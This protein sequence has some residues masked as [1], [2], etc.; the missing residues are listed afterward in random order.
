[1]FER[2]VQMNGIRGQTGISPIKIVEV[3]S[4]NKCPEQRN[5]LAMSADCDIPDGHHIRESTRDP[6]FYGGVERFTATP[7]QRRSLQFQRKRSRLTEH[8]Q[9]VGS[10]WRHDHA[11]IRG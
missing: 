7:R 3:S 2:P 11:T 4:R 8:T 9:Y 5:L 1:M 10:D 6:S